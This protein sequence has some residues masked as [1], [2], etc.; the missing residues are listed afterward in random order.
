MLAE[1]CPLERSELPVCCE[2]EHLVLSLDKI[3]YPT[4]RPKVVSF[5]Y[6]F[7]PGPSLRE[8]F[9]MEL[10]RRFGVK[11][12]VYDM[13]DLKD[14]IPALAGTDFAKPKDLEDLVSDHH[15][16]SR[17]YARRSREGA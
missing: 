5:F 7:F 4:A 11:T 6:N 10:N 16:S 2:N 8:V 12:E 15:A 3:S 9:F 1:L 14:L 13:L 17:P